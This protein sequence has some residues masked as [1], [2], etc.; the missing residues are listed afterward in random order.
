MFVLEVYDSAPK[1][2]FVMLG[3]VARQVHGAV[4]TS[5]YPNARLA[6]PL[7]L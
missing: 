6:T 3:D 4:P 2:P 5:I 1:C 7:W